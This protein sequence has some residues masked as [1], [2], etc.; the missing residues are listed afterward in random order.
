MTDPYDASAGVSAEG[1]RWRSQE[2]LEFPR[3]RQALASHAHLPISR[4]LALSLPPSYDIET[5][6]RRQQETA[7][8]CLLLDQS[9][10][11]DLSTDRDVR[12]LVRRA[13]LD[14]ILTGEEL[15]AIADSLELVRGAKAM[16]TKLHGQT[17]FL[18]AM[19]KA[20]PDMRSLERS[21]RGKLAPSGE[22][23]DDATAYL[24]QLRHEVRE[25]YQ[26]AVRPLER[27]VASEAG[28]DV[29]QERL[30]TVRA[31][32]LVVPVK[33]EFRS[34]LPGIVHDVSDSGATLFVEPLAN[35]SLCNTWR[36]RSAEEAEESL[37]IRRQLSTAVSRRATEAGQALE[38]AARLDLAM[39]KARYARAYDGAAI[40]MAD[41][42]A[43]LL[44]LFDARH[45]LFPGAVV[46]LSLAL[47]SPVS[48]LVITGPN[49]G[50]KTVALKTLGLLALMQQ[51][52]LHL[53]ADASSVLPVFDGVYADIGD[54]QDIQRSVSTFSS[55]VSNISSVL[56][57]VTS[58]SLVLLDELGT[59][60]DPEE[61]SA[62]AKAMLA[63]L[64]DR[65]VATVVTTHHRG[66]A[67]FA[68]EHSALEN[69]SLELDPETLRPTYRLTMGLPGR[70]YALAIA[71]R[72]GLDPSVIAQA[73][74][75]QDPSHLASETLLQSI[76]EERHLTSQRLRE[77]EEAQSRASALQRELEGRLEELAQAQERVVEETKREVQ[78]RAKE[79]LASLRRAE[80]A[81]SW[82]PPPS[83]V[84]DEAQHEV[85]EVQRQLRSRFWGGR[86]D[87]PVRRGGLRA[88]DLVEV[89]SLGFT[90]TVLVPPNDDR[91]V[92]VL[93]GTAKVLLPASRVRKVGEGAAPK[94][95]LASIS[96]DPAHPALDPEPALD[97]RGLRLHESLERLDALLDQALAQGRGSV[98]VIHGKGTG[99]LR[100]GVWKHLAHHPAVQQ[101]DFAERER[102]GDGATVV[103][104]G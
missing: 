14:G 47:E 61:G 88:G 80:A 22:L 40:R 82:E 26:R 74:E 64:A 101:Y 33:T 50:G 5:V 72:L 102:G 13:L 68:E 7:E 20:I 25:S 10:D 65:E 71:E 85:A 6:R 49:T 2:L 46:P 100:Q 86:A 9:G 43:P 52:G 34:R 38:M 79:V 45:P 59:S 1:L 36:E 8:A 21:I 97:L 94:P 27:L 66:V 28:G 37:R 29:L 15:V 51:S 55:H 96:L 23:L 98:L 91:K 53:S 78:E 4:E 104:L 24:R 103:E 76:Q 75:L 41:G 77:A 95:A 89:G 83:R 70:S 73:R 67:S 62:L 84:T 58:R 39:A 42:P 81:A 31:D 18:R 19:A 3:V 44:R 48:G 32:R 60:T 57:S 30:L 35:V 87:G 54:Q 16:G 99:A 56:G 63:H 90:G 93:V 69:A 17:P 12:P 11:A 92:E